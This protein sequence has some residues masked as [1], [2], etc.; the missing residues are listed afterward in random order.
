[1]RVLPLFEIRPEEALQAALEECA[2]RGWLGVPRRGEDVRPRPGCARRVDRLLRTYGLQLTWYRDPRPG[3]I[4][5]LESERVPEPPE[6]EE[7]C[8]VEREVRAVE[9]NVRYL[10]LFRV[11]VEARRALLLEEL[12]ARGWLRAWR[13]ALV[14]PQKGAW[15]AV[16]SLA[17]AYDLGVRPVNSLWGLALEIT[18][19]RCKVSGLCLV[20]EEFTLEVQEDGSVLA[21]S[22][23]FQRHYG[24]I[25]SLRTLRADKREWKEKAEL[26]RLEAAYEALCRVLPLRKVE[27]LDT[28]W[29]TRRRLRI[30]QEVVPR[31]LEWGGGVA[32]LLGG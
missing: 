22:G 25:P 19:P 15:R 26:K 32:A 21:Q 3:Y 20:R 1:M 17:R 6:P 2:R 24:H 9:L 11:S 29:D 5:V 13:G 7:E 31:F 30:L 28:T 18:G 10:P 16:A 8:G 14:Q 23:A 12:S 27:L 4:V